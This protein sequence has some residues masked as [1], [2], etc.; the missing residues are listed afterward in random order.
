MGWFS[1]GVGDYNRE[2][3][4]QRDAILSNELTTGAIR[5]SFEQ[6]QDMYAPMMSQM[7]TAAAVGA[8]A[9]TQTMQAR[10]ARMGLGGSGIGLAMGAGLRTGATMAGNRLR[11]QMAQDAMSQAYQLRASRANTMMQQA[12]GMQPEAGPGAQAMQYGMQALDAAG[13]AMAGYGAL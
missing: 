13:S 5:Q 10:M 11:A 2:L 4:A 9:D 6:F 3:K 1:S 8:M 7:G 12:L